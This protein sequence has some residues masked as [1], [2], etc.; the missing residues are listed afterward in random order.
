MIFDTHIRGV[1]HQNGAEFAIRN[2]V[3]QGEALGLRREPQNKFDKNAI[4]VWCSHGPTFL[5]FVAAELAERIAPLM[6]RGESV[7]CAFHAAPAAI[8][9]RTQTDC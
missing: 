7:T 3:K 6:D 8:V 5:G 2:H 4:G 1:R 9:L